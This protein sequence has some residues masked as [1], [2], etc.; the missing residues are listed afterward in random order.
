VQALTNP[1]LTQGAVS[2][3]TALGV[4]SEATSH[5]GHEFWP[6]DHDL[7]A[8]LMPLAATVRGHE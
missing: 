2:A 7:P 5:A 6:L 4:L 3:L 1:A 8:S